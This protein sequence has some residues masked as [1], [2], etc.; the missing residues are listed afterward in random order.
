MTKLFTIA[1]FAASILCAGDVKG[2]WTG[3]INRPDGTKQMDIVMELAQDGETITGKA[4]PRTDDM[5]P[6]EKAKLDEATF[7]FEVTTESA[8]YNVTLKLEGDSMKGGVVMSRDGQSS[9]SM[10]MELKRSA[11]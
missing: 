8:K 2:T 9:P 1:A 11:R 5:L 6:I 10:P 7:S 3:Q 4:G